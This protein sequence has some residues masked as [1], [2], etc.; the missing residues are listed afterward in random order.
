MKEKVSELIETK[1][2]NHLKEYLQSVNSADLPILFEELDDEKNL[3]VYRLLSK[4]KAAEVFAELDSDVQEKLINNFSDKELQNV[5]N[6]LFMDDTVDLIE[7]MPSNVV[8][9]IL[10][11]I[12][13]A[14]RKVINELLRLASCSLD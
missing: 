1:K 14:D 11:N 10:K 6:E 7:E 2:F 5:I 9:R 4:E 3:I 13:P 12:H 8:K